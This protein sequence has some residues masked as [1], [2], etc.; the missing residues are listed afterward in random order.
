MTAVPDEILNEM[1]VST[2]VTLRTMAVVVAWLRRMREEPD[3]IEAAKAL[4]TEIN[5]AG[6]AT[7]IKADLDDFINQIKAQRVNGSAVV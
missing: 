3:E 1:R 2:N 7:F 6:L 5:E 4:I